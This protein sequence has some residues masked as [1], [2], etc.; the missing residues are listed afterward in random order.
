MSTLFLKE[1]FCVV[2]RLLFFYSKTYL[3]NLDKYICLNLK[4]GCFNVLL[5]ANLL[6]YTRVQHH[7]DDDDNNKKYFTSQ[8]QAFLI[9][10]NNKKEITMAENTHT[11]PRELFLF[12][13]PIPQGNC[14]FASYFASQILAC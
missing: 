14:S 10:L 12:C 2:S 1:V 11:P 6:S 13:T 3:E 5:S 8:D 9:M 7:N 4:P